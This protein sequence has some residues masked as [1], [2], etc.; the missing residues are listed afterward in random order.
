MPLASNV[1]FVSVC[2]EDADIPPISV[3]TVS[4]SNAVPPDVPI[5]RLLVP[6]PMSLLNCESVLMVIVSLSLIL[7]NLSPLPSAIPNNALPT[8][9]VDVTPVPPLFSAITVPSHTPLLIVPNSV[10][11]NAF[12][13][14]NVALTLAVF[15]V[16]ELLL[17]T[18]VSK[19]DTLE[20]VIV[21]ISA[22]SRDILSLSIVPVVIFDASKLGILAVFN[23][24]LVIWLALVVSLFFNLSKFNSF[25]KLL[26]NAL[27]D[28]L[29]PS[30]AIK[31][32]VEYSLFS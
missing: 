9:V 24:P 21:G 25:F 27:S 29:V 19:S 26:D 32:F 20:A 12:T 6:A 14:A 8:A 31:E 17:D 10:M 11:S 30:P 13:L 22:A 3:A 1:L 16:T 28:C 4:P 15:A 5:A 23:V 2:V 18:S 7:M